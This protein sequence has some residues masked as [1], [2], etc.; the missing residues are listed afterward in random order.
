MNDILQPLRPQ[1]ASPSVQLQ[2]QAADIHNDARS[3]SPSFM[4]S[5]SLTT[6]RPE[7]PSTLQK[8]RLESPGRD[9]NYSRSSRSRPRIVSEST[10]STASLDEGSPSLSGRPSSLPPSSRHRPK[11]PSPLALSS[12]ESVARMAIS[13][14]ETGS[15]YLGTPP[16]SPPATDRTSRD[17]TN[18]NSTVNSS[19]KHSEKKKISTSSRSTGFRGLR[20]PLQLFDQ[21]DPLV[22]DKFGALF[23]GFRKKGPSTPNVL[24][25]QDYYNDDDLPPSFDTLRRGRDTRSSVS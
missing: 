7:L 6:F 13:A 17:S 2:L 15:N 12:S 20:R 24:V 3:N 11:R 4:S 25:S 1:D 10:S 14:V 8:R 23:S 5:G 16:Q 19:E 18:E 21:A 9:E 22:S